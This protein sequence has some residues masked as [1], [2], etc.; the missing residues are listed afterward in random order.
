MKS[1][2]MIKEVEPFRIIHPIRALRDI[3]S[4]YFNVYVIIQLTFTNL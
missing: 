3:S 1:L 4:N 2:D